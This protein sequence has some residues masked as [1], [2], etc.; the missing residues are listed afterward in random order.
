MLKRDANRLEEV[1]LHVDFDGAVGLGVGDAGEDCC[2][3]AEK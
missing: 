1:V 3:F 2:V